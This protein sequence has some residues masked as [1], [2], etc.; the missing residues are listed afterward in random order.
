MLPL[1]NFKNLVRDGVLVA[2]D[3]VCYNPEGKVL[4]GHRTNAPAKD[5]WFV[6]GGRIH[7]NETLSVAFQ[8]ITKAELGVSLQPS[9]VKMI[10]LYDHIYPENF[11]GDGSF[12]THYIILA[13][14][15][16]D[17]DGR[18]DLEHNDQN[19]EFNFFT[20]QN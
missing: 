6:P 12:N 9:D 5:Y 10:G 7:K 11:F 16:H 17:V 18:I 1:E 3:L 4:V 19:R 8:R 15:Y 2:F 20:L 14:E 13:M